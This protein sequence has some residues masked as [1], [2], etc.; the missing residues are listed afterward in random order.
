[1]QSPFLKP[2]HALRKR[3]QYRQQPQFVRDGS[4]LLKE[5]RGTVEWSHGLHQGAEAIAPVPG[6]VA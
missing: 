5:K 3:Q 2:S 1:M 4:A 6:L